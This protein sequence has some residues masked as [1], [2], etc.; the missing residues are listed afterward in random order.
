MPSLVS[1][2]ARVPAKQPL[3]LPST[4]LCCPVVRTRRRGAARLYELYSAASAAR[5]GE[6][7]SCSPRVHQVSTAS[8]RTGAFPAPGTD[9]G[10]SAPATS[11]EVLLLSAC[12]RWVLSVR[13]DVVVALPTLQ[14]SAES[15]R[16][17]AGVSRL[18]LW[19]RR[20]I[21]RQSSHSCTLQ[22]HHVGR[23]HLT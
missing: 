18:R 23:S 13:G 6:P 15:W 2:W 12:E 1:V 21:S 10:L 5:S 7:P 20:S 9:F 3:S 11:R 16:M 4:H 17:P 19:I 8:G 14:S 22:L